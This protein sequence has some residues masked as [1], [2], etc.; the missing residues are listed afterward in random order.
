MFSY[1]DKY[2]KYKQKYLELKEKKLKGGQI[3]NKCNRIEQNSY[4][5]LTQPI[6]LT[7]NLQNY[8]TNIVDP[9]ISNINDKVNFTI[10]ESNTTEIKFNYFYNEKRYEQNLKTRL[11]NTYQN[12]YTK[13]TVKSSYPP[14][15]YDF[16]NIN[17]DSSLVS[18]IIGKN[19]NLRCDER[20]IEDFIE[21]FTNSSSDA[22]IIIIDFQNYINKLYDNLKCS[23]EKSTDYKKKIIG[24]QINTMLSK[25]LEKGS[26]IFI[27]YKKSKNFDYNFLYDILS[28]P[29]NLKIYC[30]QNSSLQVLSIDIATIKNDLSLEING[31]P[32]T[33]SID[34]FIFWLISVFIYNIIKHRIESVIPQNI[35]K[36]TF[37]FRDPLPLPGKF[38][39]NVRDSR[40]ILLTNDK[41][42]LDE[43]YNNYFNDITNVYK[44][45]QIPSNNPPQKN[46]FEST[47]GDKDIIYIS[48]I[49]YE[50]D[51]IIHGNDN[52]LINYVNFL[53][54]LFGNTP[55]KLKPIESIRTFNDSHLQKLYTKFQD[56]QIILSELRTDT[57][58]LLINKYPIIQEETSD[59]SILKYIKNILDYPN[60]INVF[61]DY[62]I[63]PGL[64]FYAQIKYIQKTKYMNDNGSLTPDEIL[65]ISDEQKNLKEM[66]D[67]FNSLK[68]I[69]EQYKKCKEE[70]TE[71]KKLNE[72]ENNKTNKR[73][74]I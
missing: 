7:T 27:V 69:G 67:K 37:Q 38:S 49:L 40:F 74:R 32:Y 52:L 41:Q 11:I 73:L 71:L 18:S 46:L 50:E 53:Y 33:S 14:S 66:Y 59:Y 42:R 60:Q 62:S 58:N 23:D 43:N 68:I 55:I 24:N 17:I 39:S 70:I 21:H 45:P 51:K 6:Y 31:N 64:Y 54:N 20:D 34:D 12:K 57:I 13:V 44:L 10:T 8:F 22:S 1:K 65:N 3:V 56:N 26:Y 63:H 25:Y 4:P 61:K 16:D 72:N 28:T 15:Y 30:K 29:N 19:L 36:P 9:S 48:N 2:L 47:I 35:A 5:D